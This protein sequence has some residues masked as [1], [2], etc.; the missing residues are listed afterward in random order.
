MSK[1]RIYRIAFIY[2]DAGR[3]HVLIIRDALNSK[4]YS[5]SHKRMEWLSEAI[6]ASKSIKFIG[7]G[8]TTVLFE[9]PIQPAGWIRNDPETV[10]KR[11]GDGEGQ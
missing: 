10:G 3:K 6:K 5:M 4:E 7:A 11:V 2:P 1:N 8:P 9:A